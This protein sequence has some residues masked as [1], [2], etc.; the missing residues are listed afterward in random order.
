MSYYFKHTDTAKTGTKFDAVDYLAKKNAF[1]EKLSKGI[2]SRTKATEFRKE[3]DEIIELAKEVFRAP[4]AEVLALMKA[5]RTELDKAVATNEKKYQEALEKGNE[6]K[7]EQYID[8]TFTPELE[9]K[10]NALALSYVAELHQMH[11]QD[12]RKSDLYKKALATREGA[13][14]LLKLPLDTLPSRIQSQALNQSKSPEA[15]AFEKEQNMKL[16][17]IVTQQSALYFE[18]FRYHTIAKKID[19]AVLTLEREV[20]TSEGRAV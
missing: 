20:A 8:P 4:A 5:Y 3:L 6:I 17:Q 12:S 16:E 14:A 11:G 10:V 13:L 19:Q 15:I 18:G 9:A 7:S 2:T 1:L